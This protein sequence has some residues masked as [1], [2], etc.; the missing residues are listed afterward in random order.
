MQQI[1]KPYL[2]FLGDVMDPLAAK[3]ARGIHVW[4]PE[5]CVGQIRLAT[6]SVSL[7]LPE[8]D[9]ETAK[10]Q[11]AKTMVLGTANSGGKLPKH[12]LDAI[13]AAIRAGRGLADIAL[14]RRGCGSASSGG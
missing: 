10:A 5:A 4:R 12:W 11:G 14:R 3:T 6:D 7:G 13:K 8:L 9:I 2:L 1:P